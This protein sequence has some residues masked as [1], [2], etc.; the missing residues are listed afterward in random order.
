MSR[1]LDPLTIPLRGS[2]LIEAS[3]G[4]GKTWTIAA[5]YVRL[6]LGHGGAEAGF[7]RPLHP[8][9]ILV[10][11][12]TIAATRELSDRIRRRLVEA[13]AAFRAIDPRAIDDPFLARLADACPPGAARDD[14]AWRLATAAEAMDEAAVVTIDAWV[15]RML[16]EHA[17]DSGST[18]DERLDPDPD[19]MLDE[20]ARDY[21]RRQVYPLRGAALDDATALWATPARLA[22]NVRALIPRLD[23]R[24]SDGIDVDDVDDADPAI[25]HRRSSPPTLAQVR[26]ASLARRR[27]ALAAWK[28]GWFERLTAMRAWLADRAVT[29]KG[30]FFTGKLKAKVADG[31]FATLIAWSRDPDGIAFGVS[32]AALHR[33]SPAGLRECAIDAATLELPAGFEAFARLVPP[34]ALDAAPVAMRLHAAHAVK[35]RVRVL[36]RR[37]GIFGFQDQIERLDRALAGPAGERLRQRIVEQF[38]AAMIDE[39][40]DTSPLQYRV[41][42]RLYRTADDDPATALFLI[43]DPK[44]S[45]YGFRGADIHSYLRARTATAGRHD[46]L[47]INH[48]STAPLV[49]AVNRLFGVA[50]GHDGGAFR[51]DVDAAGGEPGPVPFV[52]VDAVD[53][54]RK[55]SE[56]FVTSAG[57]VAALT[58]VHADEPMTR[59]AVLRRFGEI[60][61]ERVAVLLDDPGCGMR[62]AGRAAGDAPFTR[63]R[64]ADVA[65]LVRDRLEA[66]TVRRAL[67]RRR[68]ASVFLSDQDSVFASDE[69]AD[70]LHWLRAVADPLDARRARVAYAT[71]LIGLPVD[72]LAALV[73]DERRLEARLEQ[74]KA[75]HRDWREQGVLSMLRQTL[76]RLDLPARWLANDGER[77]LTN[78]LH[79]A[80]LL[81]AASTTVEG[82]HA[83]IRWMGERVASGTRRGDEEI[84][85]LESDANL[86]Q[87]VTIH[88]AKGLEYPVVVIPFAS[89][90]REF[91]IKEG[92]VWVPDVDGA[93]R[94]V[95]D[96]DATDRG[97]AELDARQEDLRL[98]YVALTRARHAVWLGVAPTQVR[99]R[100]VFHESALGYLLTGGRAIDASAVAA[101]LH[102][103][104]GDLPSVR[105]ESIDGDPSLTQVSRADARPALRETKPYAAVFERDWSVGSFS[106]LVRDLRRTPRSLSS[107]SPAV[108]EELLTGPADDEPAAPGGLA[109]RLRHAR[110]RFPRGAL[111][112]NFLHDQLEWLGQEAFAITRSAT[113]DQL[114]ARCRRSGWGHR[115][116]DAVEWLTEVVTTVLPPLGVALDGL[117]H[118]ASEMEFW[119]PSEHLEADAIDRLCRHHLLGGRPRP[120]LPAQRVNGMLMGFIDLVFEVDGRYWVLDYKSNALGDTDDDY[121]PDALAGAM[122]EHRYDVQGTLYLLALHRLLRRRLGDGYD[123]ARQ[124]GGALYLFMR[125]VR[126]ATAGCHVLPADPRLLDALDRGLR[127][128]VAGASASTFAGSDAARASTSTEREADGR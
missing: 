58:I 68:I 15:Q 18:F 41:F 115:A 33:L 39:F 70:L 120:A 5:L 109:Q 73:D 96:P 108:A 121:T 24:D 111:A 38:P 62:R 119:L 123:P 86:V 99:N 124:L 92:F 107:V 47:T 8:S 49:E 77:R 45:I 34:T 4:T 78:V 91:R 55:R 40:Q 87:V 25:A 104:F 48:R 79:L 114:L 71:G 43:G 23:D 103:R 97:R 102:A 32:G 101:A 122:A 75:L 82:E 74:L 116:D 50:E 112:G 21:W 94:L 16:R 52:P 118:G 26:E 56:S 3:A 11:T 125:G 28:D 1:A 80:E 7:G 29:R 85:R 59:P 69:A 88:K 67:R 98:F 60:C 14:A 126:A 113:R 63:L 66:A 76:H 83:L 17:F 37:A 2:R 128:A 90:L 20:A 57:D 44:Q 10:M 81:Q 13:A 46:R 19:A 61:A 105:L 93:R 6:V 53:A 127:G 54:M 9:Q 72:A 117:T 84:V 35:A 22:T 36:K 12:F 100:V 106:A 42:D 95:F 110:H 65:I 31:W 64:P 89:G 30:E 51:F 27:A